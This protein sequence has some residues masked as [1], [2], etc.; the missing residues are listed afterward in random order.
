MKLFNR[1]QAIFTAIISPFAVYDNYGWNQ[2]GILMSDFTYVSIS[3]DHIQL[4]SWQNKN[5][6]LL[7]KYY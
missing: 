1:A 3:I 6:I 7:Y 4:M 2:Y 5:L